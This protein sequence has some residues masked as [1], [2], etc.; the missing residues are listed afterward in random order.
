MPANN[1]SVN[2][3]IPGFAPDPSCIRVGDTYYLVNS[4]FQY[5]PNLP[6]YTSTD[7]VNW[8]HTTNAINRRSQLSFADS[9]TR[10][11]PPDQWGESMLASGGLYAPTIRHHDGLF[12]VVCTNV[13]QRFGEDWG[14]DVRQNF[15]VTSR[16]PFG[17][18]WRKSYIVGSAVPGPMTTIKLFEIDLATGKKL[19]DEKL[20]WRGTGG[21][22]PEGPH[23]WLKDGW[24]YLVISEGGC[25]PD[26][27]ITA[28]RSRELWGPYEAYENNP[29]VTAKDTDE[30]IQHIGHSDMFTDPEGNW[31]AVCLG[32]R[33]DK[34][35]R[36][37]MGRE[38]F[39]TPMSWPKNSWPQVSQPKMTLARDLPTKRTTITAQNPEVE[40]IYLRDA[41]L[42]AHR[43]EANTITLRPTSADVTDGR[44]DAKPTFIA[45]RIRTLDRGVASVTLR[46]PSS[47]PARS[48]RSTTFNAGIAF[49]KDEHRFARLYLSQTSTPSA[50]EI[51][52]E[53]RNAGKSISRDARISV[54]SGED[55]DAKNVQLRI[56]YS[57]ETIELHYNIGKGWKGLG[58]TVDSL[59]LTGLDFTGPVVGLFACTVGDREDEL[60]GSAGQRAIVVF[61]DFSV[62]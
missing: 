13:I 56:T 38:T 16:D 2:P 26:H 51:V 6:I 44:R 22:Y 60:A 59:E 37:L 58:G 30:Y 9:F 39:L 55:E 3:I 53:L 52:F 35:S 15:I 40:Y 45:K 1:P 31:W 8:T 24:Y 34:K 21:V 32:V 61:E 29:L 33:K 11:A 19:S 18:E 43:I 41:D 42:S 50:A 47:S 10:I 7:L 46:R 12:Y 4:A 20:I 27:M 17:D 48:N 14:S 28:A 57:E 62:Q 54:P 36:Y 49:Y 25:F 23:I 5:F